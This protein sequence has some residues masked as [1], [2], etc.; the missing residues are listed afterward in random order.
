M[1]S[2]IIITIL[3]LFI[4]AT[5][6]SQTVTI[7]DVNLRN[8]LLSDYPQVMQGD[9]LDIAKARSFTG[10]LNL[11]FANIADANGIQYFNTAHTLYLDNNQL[12]TIPDISAN[13]GLEN[14]FLSNN[15]IIQLPNLSALVNLLDLQVNNN[16]L[17][18]LPNL[19]GCTKLTSIYCTNNKI[20]HLPDLT[21][22]PDLSLLVIGENPIEE[23]IDFSTCPNLTQLH[24]H[25]TT[26]K[27]LLGVE[28]LTQLEI[29]YAWGNQVTDFSAVNLLNKLTLIHIADNPLYALPKLDNK[30]NLSYVNVTN[31]NFTFET[32]LPILKSN[33]TFQ[34]EYS[35]QKNL[36]ISELNGREKGELAIE[37]PAENPLPNN[38][39]VWRKNGE[40]I[41]SSSSKVYQIES[42][43]KSDEGVYQLK[44]YNPE[45]PTLVLQSNSLP[46]SVGPCIEFKIPMVDVID[47]D[48]S[49]GYTIDLMN[50]VVL[51]GTAPYSYALKSHDFDETYTTE[52]IE[53]LPAGNYAVTITDA[54]KCSASDAVTLNRIERCDA[55]F[56]PNSDGIA[57]NFFIEH[58]GLINIYDL[59]RN[60]IKTLTGPTTWDGSTNNG[61]LADAG[62]YIIIPEKDNT[63]IY[64]TL[65]R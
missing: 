55:V 28:T 14:L 20:T 3:L 11:N 13:I 25:K 41:D 35:P 40:V 31:C 57:D 5:G 15:K 17:Q 8:K 7:P 54:K 22:F 42:L 21:Q 23:D 19:S 1:K 48:C 45:I 2:Y 10:I 53:N 65:I 12:S 36:V 16:Q 44:V 50:A 63:P 56:S 29:F 58:V 24:I 43:V 38:I 9:K 4:A 37:Y 52:K 33:P 6:W 62:Y 30:P 26:T 47:K 60:V 61:N 59:K 39:Y 46:L 49:K 32:V 27:Q 51:G 34:F 64:I 18:A